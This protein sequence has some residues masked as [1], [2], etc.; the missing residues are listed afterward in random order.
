MRLSSI[1]IRQFKRFEDLTITGIAPNTKL[2]MLTGPNG[3]G[4]TSVFE[5]F[6]YWFSCIKERYEIDTEYHLR[7][8][9]APKKNDDW[10]TTWESISPTFHGIPQFTLHK[11]LSADPVRTRKAFYIR[12]AYRHEPDFTTIGLSPSDDILLNSKAALRLILPESRVSEN[13]QRIAAESFDALYDP[14]KKKFTAEEITEQTV[15]E[16]RTSMKNVFDDLVL[17]GPTNPVTGGTFRFTK[18][19]STGFHYKNLSGGEKAAFDLLLD[20]IVKKRAFDDTIFCIDEPELH[21]HTRLQSRL[22]AELFNLV[23]PNCQLWL[24]THS[25]GMARMASQLHE[26]RPDE[27]AFLDFHGK[28]FDQ[29][30]TMG[31]V[32]PDR[33]FWKIM[34]S[35]ALDDL[36][37]L[38]APRNVV[39]CEGKKLFQNGRKPSFDVSIYRTIFSDYSASLEFLPLGGNNEVES[40]GAALANVMSAITPG[41]KIWGLFDRDDRSQEEIA[42]LQT[43]GIYVLMRRDLENYLW[44]SEIITALCAS[45][46]CPEKAQLIV[47]EKERLLNLAVSQGNAS[48]DVKAITGPLYT[49]VKATLRTELK[50]GFG[51][52]AE[53]FAIATLAPLFE[54]RRRVYQEL[55][56][57][58]LK[59]ISE[60]QPTGERPFLLTR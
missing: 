41:M 54:K 3:S 53:A 38:V 12:T 17:E 36:A 6:N 35:T 48:D 39:L 25:I 8:P 50:P 20:F 55:A 58:V 18:G 33:R 19:K 37:T 5:A 1:R 40:D 42:G 13:Y 16:V 52:D 23:P 60:D 10:K 26:R 32:N 43:K 34:F 21:M 49:F 15:G 29:T 31:P 47:S 22:L 30:V 28:D 45:L 24:S 51:N 11:S 56:S 57:I 46:G 14:S 7:T 44:D 9:N 59:P 27:I 2:V 4:K